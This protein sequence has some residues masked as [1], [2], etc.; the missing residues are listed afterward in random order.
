[1]CLLNKKVQLNQ[2]NQLDME[3]TFSVQTPRSYAEQQR[4][5]TVGNKTAS[6]T[7]G[8][9][10]I[11]NSTNLSQKSL[12]KSI[13]ISQA[14]KK[15]LEASITG[16]SRQGSFAETAKSRYASTNRLK[17]RNSRADSMLR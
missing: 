6:S 5:G 14:S 11:R 8:F 1:M 17:S 7:Q 12:P 4:P 3:E 13:Q 10:H 16:Q 15:D 9:M 2:L